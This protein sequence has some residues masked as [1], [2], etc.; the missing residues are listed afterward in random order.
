[1]RVCPANRCGCRN[2]ASHADTYIESHTYCAKRDHNASGHVY[3]YDAD[4]RASD[5]R[6][7]AGYTASC[8]GPACDGG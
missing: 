2:R 6:T 3:N 1:M 5:Y 4:N 8:A 7:D